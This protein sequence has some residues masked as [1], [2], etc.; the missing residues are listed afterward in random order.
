MEYQKTVSKCIFLEGVGLH[1][2]RE[3]A[4]QICPLEEDSGI[5]FEFE[6]KRFVVDPQSICDTNHNISLCFNG[7][8]IM[9]VE[10]LFSALFGLGIDNV[11]IKVLYG[12]EIPILDGSARV[13]VERIKESGIVK[14]N[15]KRSYLYIDREF[16]FY[17]NENQYLIVKPSDK[18][19]IDYEIDFDVIG[20]EYITF[21]FSEDSF[22]KEISSARTFGFIEDAERFKKIGLALGA[23][24]ENV[25]IYSKVEKM[26]LNGD[27]YP[28]ENV[29]HKVLDLLGA[30]AILYPRVIGRFIAKKSGHLIDCELVKLIYNHYMS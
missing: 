9:T 10:H 20:K 18:I 11:L 6:G 12:E 16:S 8:K 22:V 4:I 15:N 26:S 23:S 27:R 13:F 29:R 5:V 7:H 30:L 3:S 14:Q 2:G 21:E 1:T 19:I 28:N 24:M 17:K 25:H